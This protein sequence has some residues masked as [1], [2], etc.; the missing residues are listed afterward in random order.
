MHSVTTVI[1]MIHVKKLAYVHMWLMIVQPFQ[2]VITNKNIN[3]LLS[4]MASNK[5]GAFTSLYVISSRT[6]HT[7]ISPFKASIQN[8]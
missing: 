7:S 5:L 8:T 4:F 6:V 3:R 2:R 1:W